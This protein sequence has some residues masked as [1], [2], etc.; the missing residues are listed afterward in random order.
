MWVDDVAELI[1]MCIERGLTGVLNAVTGIA[2]SFG[3]LAE[4]IVQLSGRKVVVERRPRASQVTHRH[5]DTSAL[6]RAFPWFRPT[7]LDD[8]LKMSL[9]E[10][11]EREVV[12]PQC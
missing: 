12:C 9:A 3:D 1:R 6:A 4:K 7:S 8:G 5:F 2:I 10:L 11:S